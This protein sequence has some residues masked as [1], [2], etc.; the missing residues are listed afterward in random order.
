MTVAPYDAVADEYYE[1]SHKTCRNFDQTT[2]AA[3]AS[4]RSLVPKGGL[5]LDVG[6][7]RGRCGEYLDVDCSRV[8]QLDSSAKML[9]LIP[10]EESLLR[11]LHPADKLPFSDEQFSCVAAFL[12]DPFLG[13]NFLSEAWRVLR[14]GGLFIATTPAYEWGAPL[15]ASLGLDL[16]STRFVTRTGMAIVPSVLVPMTRL[17]E[18]LVFAGFSINHIALTSHKLPFGDGP[19]SG[20]IAGPAQALGREPHELEILYTVVVSK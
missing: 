15:R 7:G 2:R 13:L 11:V 12:C 10:R 3:L 19:I 4:V 8:V 1:L 18:M 6:A 20:D 14:G 9:S 5:I 17:R 16:Y